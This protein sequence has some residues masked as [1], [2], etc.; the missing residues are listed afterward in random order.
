MEDVTRLSPGGLVRA[1]G[2]VEV[3]LERDQARVGQLAL[4]I[5]IE[6]A[7]VAPRTQVRHHEGSTKFYEKS[8]IMDRAQS[9]PWWCLRRAHGRG[10]KNYCTVVLWATNTS[11]SE[12]RFFPCL[13][14]AHP[15]EHAPSTNMFVLVRFPP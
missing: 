13:R 3:E 5:P 11:T 15:G 8:T 12:A 1:Q 4:G 14:R 7:L 9:V 6:A 10:E 2:R